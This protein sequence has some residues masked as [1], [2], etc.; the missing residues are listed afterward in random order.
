[1]IN[2][3]KNILQPA[4]M[5]SGII[6]GAGVFSLPYVFLS[7]GLA[8][9]FFYLGFF[10]LIYIFLYFIY[11]DIIVR[12]AGEHRFVGYADIY[13]GKAGLS[14]S[15]LIGL[16]QLFFVMTIYLILA[17]SFSKLFIGGDAVYHLFAFWLAG[18]A[19]IFLDSRKLAFSEF[20]IVIGIALIMALIFF[21]G[22]PAFIFSG[23][24]FGSLDLSKFL[25]VG[26][27]LFALSGSLAVPEIFGYFRDAKIPLSYMKNSLALG[28]FVPILA[29]GGFVMG[30]IGLS[31]VVSEDSVSGLIGNVP[32][33]LL[34]L[35]GILG[36]FSLVS[37]Y[38]IVGTNVRKIIRQDLKMQALAGGSAAVFLPI[39]L[40]FAGFQSFLGAVS[41][42]GT[43]FLPMES[44]LLILIWLQVNKISKVPPMF[45]GRWTRIAV[46]VILFVFFVSLFYAIL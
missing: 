21:L 20:L 46:P 37:S 29:Y 28:G 16:L 35:V 39:A 13:L 4:S 2:F 40:Y 34:W 31:G 14:I 24:S 32:D 38:I 12:T 30:I 36:I 18:S 19:L 23:I 7:A 27:I 17:P 9:S 41:F 42:V 33:I 43:L 1:M 15:L 26:P 44:I 8:T 6:I 5:L 11:A 25:S 10:G 22:L 45:A 3:L